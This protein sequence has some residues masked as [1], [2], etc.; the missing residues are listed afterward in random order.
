VF[1]GAKM[2][3]ADVVKVPVYLSL[4]VIVA[5]LAIAVAASLRTTAAPEPADSRAS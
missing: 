3:L 4:G 5:M 2:T 1:V